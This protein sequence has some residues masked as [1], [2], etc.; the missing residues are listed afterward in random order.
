MGNDGDGCDPVRLCE[1][2]TDES[3][4]IKNLQRPREDCERF[5][6]E[7]LRG[8]GLNDPPSEPATSTLIRQK[9]ADGPGANDH[10][11]RLH[12]HCAIRHA[13]SSLSLS[14]S[15]LSLSLA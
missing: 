5:R 2:R 12:I 3:G 4:H 10:N 11:L 14:L 15:S 6:M 8:V 13:S 1:K 7:R 9:Q